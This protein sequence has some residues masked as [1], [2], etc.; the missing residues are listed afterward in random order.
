MNKFTCGRR[1]EDGTEDPN[2]VF[3][4]S[5]TDKD[6]YQEDGTCSYCGSLSPEL[7]LDG[8]EKGELEVEPTDKNYKVYVRRLAGEKLPL[9]SGN[10][11]KFYFQHFSAE[12]KHKFIDMV[13][14][15]RI[16][17]GTPGYFYRLP[18]FME[19]EKKT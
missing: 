18:F 19:I 15:K 14:E 13:N 10:M 17:F 5:G 4:F 9:P 1:G 7:F 8:I 2:G 11:G 6:S 16:K 12:Q 3:K